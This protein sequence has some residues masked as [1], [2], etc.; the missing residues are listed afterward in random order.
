MR[1]RAVRTVFQVK[2]DEFKS[3]HL[4]FAD[5]MYLCKMVR[6]ENR[7]FADPPRRLQESGLLY[8]DHRSDGMGGVVY[9]NGYRATETAAEY[10]RYWIKKKLSMLFTALIAI[11]SVLYH[12]I[13][14][15]KEELIQFFTTHVR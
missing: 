15:W 12:I 7:F 6:N 3:I 13:L 8:R 11:L 2:R 14:D 10:C 4:S 9:R 1:I 5:W